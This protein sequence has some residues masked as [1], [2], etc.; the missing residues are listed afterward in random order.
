MKTAARS[1]RSCRAR[2]R[3]IRSTAAQRRGRLFPMAIGCAKIVAAPLT[4]EPWRICASGSAG[5]SGEAPARRRPGHTDAT[6]P[7]AMISAYVRSVSATTS[8]RS[9]GGIVTSRVTAANPRISTLIVHAPASSV[10]KRKTPCSSD[11]TVTVRSPLVAVMV[12]P[13]TGWPACT[14]RPESIASGPR[15]SRRSQLCGE[16][17]S[18]R[19]LL[20]GEGGAGDPVETATTIAAVRSWQFGFRPLHAV[21][22]EVL[23]R[24]ARLGSASGRGFERLEDRR[25]IGRDRLARGL[26]RQSAAGRAGSQTPRRSSAAP[27]RH[28]ASGR[29]GHRRA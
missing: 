14:T 15:L 8:S 26:R 28:P 18:R 20:C 22:D 12:A 23:R 1:R 2:R 13:G 10:S 17:G 6:A 4:T 21:D 29:P 24:P 11:V 16:G 27:A 7:A 25:A 19:S 3:T 9:L 5:L